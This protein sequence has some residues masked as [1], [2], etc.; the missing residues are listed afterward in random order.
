MWKVEWVEEC[1]NGDEILH[2]KTFTDEE[3]AREFWE[4][5][6]EDFVETFGIKRVS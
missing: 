5:L 1:E 2:V 6:V 4:M 3:D